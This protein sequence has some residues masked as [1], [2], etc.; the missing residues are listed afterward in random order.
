M[1]E[2]SLSRVDAVLFDLDG[3]LIDTAPDLAAAL[4]AVLKK[5][6]RSTLPYSAIRPTVSNG[7][8]GLIKLGFGDS[9]SSEQ[10]EKIKADLIAYYQQ[11]IADKS[12]LFEGLDSA[13]LHLERNNIPWGIVTNKPEYLTR[14]LLKKLSLLD[15]SSC[16]VCGDQVANSKPHPEPIFL[17]CK[18]LDV[19]PENTLYI[20]DAERDIRAGRLA[21]LKTIACAYGYI[22]DTEDINAW[23]ANT[24]VETPQELLALLTSIRLKGQ[25]I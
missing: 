21:G 16:V 2:I 3:A 23:Q 7:A 24:L 4:N 5:N 22:P 13:L 6:N 17:A 1:L 8:N 19:M 12:R 15:K 14:P 9:L 10:H 20:G 25:S 11:H 18:Q